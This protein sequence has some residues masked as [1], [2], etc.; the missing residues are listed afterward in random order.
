MIAVK[1]FLGYPVDEQFAEALNEQNPALVSLL[2][3][4][5]DSYLQWTNR[6]DI[7]FLGKFIDENPK[8]SSL[9]LF[10]A[11]IYSLLQKLAPA[12]PIKE[13]PLWLFPIVKE[14]AAGR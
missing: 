5:G 8:M 9:D 10:E 14:N 2:I 7:P 6:E 4:E 13:K 3:Q 12:L 11:N 1:L